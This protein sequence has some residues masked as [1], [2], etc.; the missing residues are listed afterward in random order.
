MADNQQILVVKGWEGFADRLQILSDSIHYCITHKAIL[1]VDWRDYMWGQKEKDFSDYFELVD[2]PTIPLADVVE[3][4]K[5]GASIMPK[6]WTPH[7]L[8]SVPTEIIHYDNYKLNFDNYQK[9]DSD[10]VVINGKGLRTWHIDNLINNI[11]IKSTLIPT[12][13]ERLCVL[14]LPYTSIHL[15]GTDRFSPDSLK[16]TN[17]EYEALPPH[18]KARVYV[19]SDMKELI[20]AWTKKYP[21]VQRIEENPCIFKLPSSKYPTHMY[22]AEALKFYGVTKDELNINTLVDFLVIAFS[23]STYGNNES[24]FISMGRMMRQGGVDGVGKWLDGFTP[25]RAAL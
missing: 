23:N 14:K 18:L 17:A 24:V 21:T 12:I 16:I 2:V 13:V 25:D 1:C 4:L 9:I 7:L 22:E 11:K 20:D 8:S 10:I 3:Q 6:A 5:N 15:R 19:I